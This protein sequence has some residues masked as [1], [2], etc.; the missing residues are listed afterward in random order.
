MQ[1]IEKNTTHLSNILNYNLKSPEKS[2]NDLIRPRKLKLDKTLAKY[3]MN[4]SL[5]VSPVSE[6]R[7]FSDY[8]EQKK[9]EAT[10]NRKSFSYYIDLQE[11]TNTEESFKQVCDDIEQFSRDFNKKYEQIATNQP[12]KDE[13]EMK[14]EDFDCGYEPVKQ[15]DDDDGNFSSDS[16]EDYSF[17][18]AKPNASKKQTVPR[19]C[20]SNNEIYK[21]QEMEYVEDIPKSES[22][23]L[24]P[25]IR[26]SQDSIL[27]DEHQL[28]YDYQKSYCNSM[29]SVL[30]NE[31]D[32][33][34]AP[35]E[36]LFKK[37]H[38]SRMLHSQ[39]LPKNITCE[40][41]SLSRSVPKEFGYDCSLYNYDNFRFDQ[42]PQVGGNDVKRSK[43][44]YESCASKSTLKTS[45]TQ[46]DFVTPEQIVAKKKNASEDFQKK[47][48]KFETTIAQHNKKPVSFFV[49][50]SKK[51]SKEN[52]PVRNTA[53]DNKLAKKDNTDMYIPS[54]A[55]K[56]KQYKSKFCNVLN[57]K[58]EFNI[59]IYESGHSRQNQNFF[60]LST[61]NFDK[62]KNKNKVV[63]ETSSLDRHLFTKS[64]LNSEKVTH[65]PPKSV[66]R[67]SSKTRKTKTSYEYV[68]KEDF[69][70][71]SC[72]NNNKS[73]LNNAFE[74]KT[75]EICYKEKNF[76]CDLEMSNRQQSSILTELYDSLD[77]N[78]FSTKNDLDSLEV[79]LN[80][81][82]SEEKIY[83]SL[84]CNL[85][86][87]NNPT[88]QNTMK[89]QPPDN[90]IQLDLENI[91]ILNEIQRKIQKINNLIDVFRKNVT[92]G[93][94]R[95]LSSLYESLHNS[96]SYY[97][98]L[99]KLQ[100]TPLKF[101]RRNLSLPSFVERRL[102]FEAKAKT[103]PRA[104]QAEEE[105]R[106][107]AHEDEP[108]LCLC[109]N[110]MDIEEPRFIRVS[111]MSF[112][113]YMEVF[114]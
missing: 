87:K 91:K 41:D 58:P 77:K 110:A 112:I 51:C 53:L 15:T 48:L 32:C 72:K 96:Q 113:F 19:R 59:D 70:Q 49:D 101:R 54:L 14:Y 5:P 109:I 92:Y 68:K 62:P 43:S 83:D 39:S 64:L 1:D 35:L 10:S 7:Q 89:K 105:G 9:Y 24:N 98:D 40:I 75:I 8:I 90:K 93:K 102:N 47:L 103:K 108:P 55:S 34:S 66:R 50:N 11:K 88:K 60:T 33:K 26:T 27:S 71:S 79:N 29:E 16:L 74:E 6:E 30:S 69:Y 81:G 21:L 85:W 97:N 38:D 42:S 25:H 2:L 67:H 52:V 12:V 78:I 84:E 61:V 106:R 3:K 4:K 86:T 23:Y 95:A 107:H 36:A 65:K 45:Q 100:T 111:R 37:C 76:D 73:V 63:Q 31:S 104:A 80:T 22:F 28:D 94:V 82:E 13:L 17:R 57:N 46:T 44:M 20:M 18:S 114:I 99:T 56:N